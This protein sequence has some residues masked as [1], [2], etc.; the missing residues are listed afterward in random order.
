M[1]TINNML[2]DINVHLMMV[3]S[4]LDRPEKAYHHASEIRDIAGQL[5]NELFRQERRSGEVKGI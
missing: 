2:R 3:E 5:M 4:L 1:K